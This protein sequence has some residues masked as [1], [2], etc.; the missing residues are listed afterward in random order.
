MK[1]LII[2]LFVFCTATGFAQ[3]EKDALLKRDSLQLQ[4]QFT[5]MYYLH[6][7]AGE[8]MCMG[9]MDKLK[10]DRVFG[11]YFNTVIAE[12]PVTSINVINYLGGKL[13]T[14]WDEFMETVYTKNFNALTDIISTYGYPSF[15]RYKILPIDDHA[16]QAVT[17]ALH[18]NKEQRKAFQKIIKK[19]YKL[20]NIDKNEFESTIFLTDTE[21]MSSEK[22]RKYTETHKDVRILK[23]S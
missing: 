5:L 18:T 22:F 14:N 7:K 2:I 8:G 6:K 4:Q 9:Y 17:F 23:K 12:N 19:E 15:K 11:E 1:Q 16:T 20:K 10:S 3:A 21:G 13:P